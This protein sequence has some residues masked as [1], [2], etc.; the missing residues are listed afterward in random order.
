M[1]TIQIMMSPPRT[2]I[3]S[4]LFRGNVVTPLTTAFQIRYAIANPTCAA[5]IMRYMCRHDG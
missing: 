1:L 3:T 2:A 5:I 4:V